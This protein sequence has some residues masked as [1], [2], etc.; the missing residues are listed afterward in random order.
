MTQA[1]LVDLDDTVL[2]YTVDVDAS[3]EGACGAAA[4]KLV[5]DVPALVRAISET[6][7]WFWLDP[8]RAAEERRDMLRAWTRIAAHA[9][10]QC[11]VRAD[12]LCDVIAGEFLRRRWEKMK[13][14]PE[15]LDTLARLRDR[16]VPLALVTNGD[17]TQQRRKIESFGLA[18][19]FDAIVIEGEFG[20]G[21]PHESVYRHVLDA[22]GVAPSSA[23]MVGDNLEWDV[24][25]P[26]R[27]GLRGIWIDR[28]GAGLPGDA[29]VTPHHIIRSLTELLDLL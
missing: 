23:W 12:G 14:F 25:A 17:A 5:A 7:R 11:G 24:A 29:G 16:G 20:V 27:L 21:K 13:L 4:A 2:D 19:L 18:S 1:L 22:L 6:R 9:L 3:W 28:P 15:A 26:Q 8:E 10:E